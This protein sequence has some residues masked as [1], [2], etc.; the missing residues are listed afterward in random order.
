MFVKEDLAKYK[1]FKS[2]ILK[3]KLDIQCEAVIAAAS[4]FQWFFSLEKK[5]SESILPEKAAEKV[6]QGKKN[7]SCE[8]NN[9]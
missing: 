1:A 7:V 6:L 3:S 5:I 8:S 9:K 2:V 4:L